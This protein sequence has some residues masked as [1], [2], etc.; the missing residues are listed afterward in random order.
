MTENTKSLTVGEKYLYTGENPSVNSEAPLIFIG[1]KEKLAQFIADDQSLYDLLG[2]AFSKSAFDDYVNKNDIDELGKNVN[3]IRS[4]EIDA[5]VSQGET[6]CHVKVLEAK[7]QNARKLMAKHSKKVFYATDCPRG[8]TYMQFI[9]EFKSECAKQR[10]PTIG[11]TF[12]GY[13]NENKLSIAHNGT[14]IESDTLDL[15]SHGHVYFSL[16]KDPKYARMNID[17]M[18]GTSTPEI[19]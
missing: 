10:L 3:V 14:D 9:K 13:D 7:L 18:C 15:P 19:D 6:N 12:H 1:T 5:W 17:Y 11:F 8:E 16:K 4:H 2:E